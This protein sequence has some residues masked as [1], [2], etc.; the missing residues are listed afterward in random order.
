[1]KALPLVSVFKKTLLGLAGAVA[2]AAVTTTAQA[3]LIS[4]AWTDNGNGTVR[5]WGEH[6]H[7]DLSAPS[8]AN[9]GITI[10][11]LSGSITPFT[12]QWTGHLN[13][14]DRDAMVS[15]GTL[16]GF[17]DAG[18]GF[19]KYG[20]WMYTEDLVIGN[21]DWQFFTGTNCCI[22]TMGAPV[23]VTLTGITS[24]D[25]GTGPSSAVPEPGTLAVIGLAIGGLGFG[26]R[27]VK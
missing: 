17:A 4:F 15:A 27:F 2:L 13:N 16:T 10:T 7:G 5:L 9:G 18:N 20:D 23:S 19:A 21:G 22:D 12:A 26:R 25:A 1:M 24:V 14:S 8:T 11:D 6:W 3:H